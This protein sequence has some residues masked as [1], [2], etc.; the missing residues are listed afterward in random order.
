M[1]K[2]SIVIPYYNRLN[3]LRHTIKSIARTQY[4]DYEI[5]IVNDAGDINNLNI[6]KDFDDIHNKIKVIDISKEE[7]KERTNPSIPFNKGLTYATGDIIVI[8][9]PESYHNGDILEH[10]S[11]NIGP[12][13]YY[14]YSAYNLHSDK[15]N[16]QFFVNDDKSINALSKIERITGMLEW[17]QHPVHRNYKY[18]FCAASYRH[19]FEIIGGFDEEYANGV[20]FDDDDLVLKVESIARL[21]VVSVPPE[22][23]PFIVN[24]YHHPSTSTNI[25]T[26]SDDNIVKKKWLLN[27]ELF[28]TKK[29]SINP[30]FNYPR[31]V[32]FFWYGRLTFLNYLS[33]LSFHK[34]HPTWVI[35]IYRST[36]AD[37]K[38][39]WNTGEQKKFNKSIDDYFG[40]L[41]HLS[42]VNIMDAN[43]IVIE[44][45]IQNIYMVH[46]SDI[47][48]MYLL[49]KF[50]G[51]YSDFDIIYTENIEKYFV[52]KTNTII[53]DR[54]AGDTVT[55]YYPNALFLAKRGCNFCKFIVDRQLEE[56]KNNKLDGYST[57]GPVIFGKIFR[58]SKYKSIKQCIEIMDGKCYLPLEWNEIDKLYD[59]Q[60]F[61]TTQPYFGI[62][63]F[64]GAARSREYIENF[65]INNNKMKCTMDKIVGIYTNDL[66]EARLKSN[67]KNK[68]QLYYESIYADIYSDKSLETISGTGSTREQTGILVNDLELLIKKFSITSI[69]D[70]GCGD[71]NWIKYI[72]MNN[73]KYIG[74][75]IVD[76]IIADNKKKFAG[77]DKMD[78]YC[79]DIISDPTPCV[80]LIICR[81]TLVQLPYADILQ[82]LSNFKKSGSK[83]ILMTHFSGNR[84]NSNVNVGQWRTLTF[85]ANPFNFSNP[86]DIINENCT[87]CNGLYSDKCMAL[88]KLSDI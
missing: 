58:N 57:V 47:M 45:N 38:H 36:F 3:L 64:N 63:W 46:Q 26:V 73:S 67:E 19:N 35:N 29:N 17:Y 86:T 88:W 54:T 33:I 13:D 10:I 14:I 25:S 53:F 12:D 30:N 15:A 68:I 43:K 76:Y 23:N 65:D 83:Y 62:H 7:K 44:L 81:D 8:Q 20:C 2:I 40:A 74:V 28:A 59:K 48:R 87:E 77:R 69:L 49:N 21:N 37:S 42:Y 6:K 4:T 55:V 18:H 66:M 82:I 61:A 9:N 80:D 84:K 24:L 1:V 27:K 71:L 16:K 75:D 5:V 70:A 52:D 60:N 31:I 39:K 32:Y 79:M 34:Y 11:K 56:I 78:F 22:S 50:G 85:T 41:K 72:N 51:M